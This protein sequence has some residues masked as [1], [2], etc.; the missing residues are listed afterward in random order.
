MRGSME[1]EYRISSI[2]EKGLEITRKYPLCDHCL[3]RMF[4][5]I[6]LELGNDE[7]GKAIKVLMNMKLHELLKAGSIGKDELKIFAVNNGDPI[8]RLYRKIY[9]EEIIP[10]LCYICGNKLSRK[11]FEEHAEKISMLLK[12]YDAST[13]LIGVSI[14]RELALKELEV[15]ELV[16]LETSESIKNEIKREIGKIIK[17]RYGYEPDF[18]HPD[19][20]VIIDYS[21]DTYNIVVNPILYEGLYWKRGRNISHTIWISHRGVKEYPYSLE[22]FLNDRLRELF[23]SERIIHHASGRE[24]VDARMLGTGRPVVVEV[25]NPRKRRID[26]DTINNVLRTH[27]IEFRLFKPSSRSRIEYLK[28]EASKKAKIYKVLFYVDE[29]I[30]DEKIG[31]LM[32]KFKNIVI[33]QRTP[34]RI[35]RR[36]KDVIRR[37]KVYGVRVRRIHGR[38]YEALIWCDGGLYV[39]ELIHCDNGRTKPCFGEILGVNTYP[40]ELDVIG[41]EVE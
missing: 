35:L 41:I 38:I 23:R 17:N 24:D 8:T 28:G 34:T 16:R 5:K 21:T 32:E 12:E 29:D 36:K 22:E 9:N 27:V 18:E 37:R 20:V 15:A 31:E 1:R 33:E 30:D 25:K 40:V 39:K 7:R 11:Y 3:G 2:V 26:L 13:F 19:V 6:G 14:S 10:K 4:A